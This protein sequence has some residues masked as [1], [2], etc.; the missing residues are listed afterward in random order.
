MSGVSWQRHVVI[1]VVQPVFSSQAKIN[2]G[3]K[4]ITKQAEERAQLKIIKIFIKN[5]YI[6]CKQDECAKDD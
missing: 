3:V 5:K 1:S 4:N 6:I 2:N